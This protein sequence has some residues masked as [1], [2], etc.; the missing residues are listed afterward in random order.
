M[1]R[2]YFTQHFFDKTNNLAIYAELIMIKSYNQTLE[3]FCFMS[4][5]I[6]VKNIKTQKQDICML[7]NCSRTFMFQL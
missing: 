2:V 7:C 3:I 5:K 1:G 6:T 4:A